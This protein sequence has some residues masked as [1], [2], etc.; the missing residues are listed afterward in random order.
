[1]AASN[2]AVMHRAQRWQLVAAIVALGLLIWLLG[3][4][5]TPFAVAAMLA[6][7]ADPVIDRLMRAGLSRTWAV[8][9]VSSLLL[10][11]LVL[12]LIL[13]LPALQQQ[14]VE[15]IESV[16]RYVVWYNETAAPW[17]SEHLRLPVETFDPD[18]L[19]GVLRDNWEKAGGVVATVLTWFSRSGLAL[20]GILI[21]IALIPV[22]AFYFMRDWDHMILAIHRLVPRPIE[23]TV[24]RLAREADSTLGGFLRGQLLVMIVL[25]FVY[26]FGLMIAGID[27]SLL[28]GLIAGLVS[29]VPYLGGIV[30]VGAGVIAAL[31]QHGD[32]LHVVY[33]LI[34]FAIGQALES[35]FLTPWLVGDKIGMHPV[36]VMFAVLAGGQLFGFVGVLLALPVAAVAM[37]LLRFAYGHYLASRFYGGVAPSAPLNPTGVQL[38]AADGQPLP[39]T[40][41]ESSS[42][43]PAGNT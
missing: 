16:P 17:L 36:A 43:D 9:V 5:L 38:L 21:N 18:R 1:M 42:V 14:I 33:V 25:G 24:T 23:P 19:A 26:G 22:V 3:P 11:G 27:F 28:I 7:V 30:F 15:L 37:V 32:I 20:L 4:V 29:F 8:V 35:F 34:A 12:A 6:Y 10:L 31:V 40:I 2:R 41:V 13:L 39:G